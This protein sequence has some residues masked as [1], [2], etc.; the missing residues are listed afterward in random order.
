MYNKHTPVLELEMKE[1]TVEKV[2]S[3]LDR[4]H[5]PIV[6][7]KK[8]KP[9]EKELNDWIKGRGIREKR[10]G[11]LMVRQEF[12]EIPVDR[13]MFSLSD[14]YWFQYKKEETWDKLNFFTNP[15]SE[16]VG[17]AFFTPWELPRD[18]YFPPSPDTMTNGLLRKKWVRGRDGTSYLIKA[19]S[20]PLHQ[21]PITEV[22]AS[23]MLGKLHIIPYVKYELIV[24]GL[25]LCSRCKNFVDEDTEF[26]PASHIFLSEPRKMNVTTH[27]HMLRMCKKY[28]V[29]GAAGYIDRMIFVDH[30]IGNDDRHLGNFGFIRDVETAKITGFAPLFDSGSSYGV[31]NGQK[32]TSRYFE[33]RE[34]TAIRNLIG[35]IDLNKLRDHR[36]AYSLIDTYPE[37]TREQK[38]I[39]KIFMEDM[40]KEMQEEAERRERGDHQSNLSHDIS[41]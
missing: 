37:I 29:K 25:R 38:T 7:Q 6:L 1:R 20:K 24:D 41:R 23:I 19:G 9:T 34:K 28:G 35:K 17:K 2:V 12:G 33:D 10:E 39:L 11:M 27:D 14:Q 22:L 16:D 31:I 32:G 3:C 40:E 5:L 15:Y 26:V 21:E 13:C 4:D 30:I 18:H 8:E 36:E